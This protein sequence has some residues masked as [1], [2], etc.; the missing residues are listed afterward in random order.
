MTALGPDGALEVIATFFVLMVC[1]IKISGDSPLHIKEPQL[2]KFKATDPANHLYPH[3]NYANMHDQSPVFFDPEREL[4]WIVRHDLIQYVNKNPQTFSSHVELF[5]GT[6]INGYPESV[7]E[8]RA[9]GVGHGDTL[10]T[11]NDRDS[12][13]AYKEIVQRA[14]S[15]RR[16]LMFEQQTKDLAS[17]LIDEIPESGEIDFSAQFAVPLTFTVICRQLGIEE[18]MLP[19]FKK[20]SDSIDVLL[21]NMADEQALISAAK[22]EL[23][24]QKYMIER[25]ELRRQDPKEDVIS[26]IVTARFKG[27]RL[28]TDMEL[29]GILNQLF[30]AGNEST[31]STLIGAIYYLT[32]Q[33]EIYARIREGGQP[34]IKV[35]V[36]EVLRMWSAVQGL[37]RTTLHDTELEGVTIPKGAKVHIRYGAANVDPSA[38]D[39]PCEIDLER[40]NPR[41]H[42]SFGYGI[43]HCVG[44]ALARQELVTA[45]D[46]LTTRFS[47][48]TLE[49]P[50]K[51]FHFFSSYHLRSLEVM[52]VKFWA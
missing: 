23:E 47:K 34:V 31:R 3:D 12:H 18:E 44:A 39:N 50:H 51:D 46:L 52:K 6:G 2:L 36:E 43:H 45:I 9:R 35:F 13:R 1:M 20:W 4:Y 8:I 30:V 27:E 38:F 15:P 29:F 14:F 40:P 28:L 5:G 25:C 21:S 48:V 32:Q 17:R 10:I 19:T 42:L 7:Q 26:D 49:Q 16:V 33:P 24:L 37:Y 22:D 41:N 11:N